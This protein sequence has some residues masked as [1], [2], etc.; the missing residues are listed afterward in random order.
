MF[1]LFYFSCLDHSEGTAKN[2][3][4]R[5]FTRWQLL[6]SKYIANIIGVFCDVFDCCSEFL[7]A[8]TSAK[9]EKLNNLLSV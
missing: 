2:I 1:V 7:S 4:G 8:N 3:I 5:G 9:T 6:I